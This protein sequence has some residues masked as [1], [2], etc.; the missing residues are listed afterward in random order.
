MRQKFNVD[1]SENATLRCGGADVSYFMCGLLAC[2]VTDGMLHLFCYEKFP[3]SLWV[4]L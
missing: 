2:T 4:I 3:T 1:L